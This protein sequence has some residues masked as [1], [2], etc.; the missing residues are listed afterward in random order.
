MKGDE[1]MKRI[2][3]LLTALLCMLAAACAAPEQTAKSPQ[4]TQQTP[5]AGVEIPEPL[6]QDAATAAYEQILEVV[7]GP[8]QGE[9][10]YPPEFGDCYYQDGYLWVCLTENT[11]WMQ[12]KYQAMVDT[13]QIL[14]FKEVAYSYND[15]YA[16]QMAI[17]ETAGVEWST[18]GVDVME[19]RVDVT[20]PD[21][22]E[23]REAL[24]RIVD[25]LPED[26]ADRFAEYPIVFEAGAALA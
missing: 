3:F 19:N 17:T 12:Q 24:A 21:L 20:I 4:E 6:G 11:P 22:A 14:R 5:A 16:L 1:A 10:N 9:P 2:L 18:V 7:S 15:L 8:P 13:P 23:A 25:Q 26:V